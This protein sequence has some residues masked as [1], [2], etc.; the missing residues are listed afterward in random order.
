M[1]LH[2]FII[3]RDIAK[4]GSLDPKQLKEAA[5]KSNEVLRKLG[6]DIQWVESYI[7]D[8]KL[9][10]VYLATSEDIIRKHAQMSGFPATKIIPI[11]RTID[12]TTAQSSVGPVPI[13]H[14]L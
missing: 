11:H 4:A 13:G 6:P 3:E 14:A 9:F 12:P 8:D 10:C 1:P 2:R 7:A 5:V